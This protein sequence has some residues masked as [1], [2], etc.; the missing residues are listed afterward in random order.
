[1]QSDT[2]PSSLQQLGFKWEWNLN[3]VVVLVGFASS[4]VAWGYSQAEN[5]ASLDR[6]NRNIERL[7]AESNAMDLRLQLIERTQVKSEQTEYRITLLEK[8]QENFDTRV[9]RITESYSNQFADFRTQLSAISTQIALSQQT[10]Q[11][12][13]ARPPTTPTAP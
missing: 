4:F 9:N 6:S 2:R 10:L 12:I 3:T 1:M 7:T 13:E 8:G 11:R 5:R